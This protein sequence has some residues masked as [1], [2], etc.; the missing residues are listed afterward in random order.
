M[1]VRASGN[2]G[3]YTRQG[4]SRRGRADGGLAGGAG[5]QVRPAT[6]ARGRRE[7]HGGRVRRRAARRRA[8]HRARRQL[9]RRPRGSTRGVRPRRRRRARGSSTV[10]HAQLQRAHSRPAQHVVFLGGPR[11]SFNCLGYFKH[12]HPC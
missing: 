2:G 3:L 1:C 5:G 11:N 12:V 8:G 10:D 9:G 7:A 4:D 6:L